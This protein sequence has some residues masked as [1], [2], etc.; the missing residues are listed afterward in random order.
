MPLNAAYRLSGGNVVMMDMM[1][2]YLCLS[3]SRATSSCFPLITSG[4][5]GGKASRISRRKVLSSV[6][7]TLTLC[8][9]GER[10]LFTYISLFPDLQACVLSSV[11]LQVLTSSCFKL[12][13]VH[14]IPV[15]SNKDG[16]KEHTEPAVA[17]PLSDFQSTENR[18][19]HRTAT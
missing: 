16:K 1:S 12:R 3:I 11:E 18:L 9:R 7:V 2:W 10:A 14:N 17:P 6:S 15:T 8:R 13:T 4:P 19:F 5:S